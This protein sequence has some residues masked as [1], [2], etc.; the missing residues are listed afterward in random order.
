MREKD[1]VPR[2]ELGLVEELVAI[3]VKVG[4]NGA[5]VVSGSCAGEQR[6]STEIVN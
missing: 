3:D 1:V 5:S 2:L 4:D 6:M